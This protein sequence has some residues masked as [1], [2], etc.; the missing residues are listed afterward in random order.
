MDGARQKVEF[1]PS[2]D[3]SQGCTTHRVGEEPRGPQV[4]A[5]SEA[6]LALLPFAKRHLFGERLAAAKNLQG[7]RVAWPIHRNQRCQRIEIL[8]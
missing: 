5:I 8:G 7:N 2:S 1:Y 3:G 6:V 4:A